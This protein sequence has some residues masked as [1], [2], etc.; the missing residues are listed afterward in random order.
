MVE[1]PADIRAPDTPR[2]S[3]A[4]RSP[5]PTSSADSRILIRGVRELQYRP[6]APVRD[7]EAEEMLHELRVEREGVVRG[8]DVESTLPD[9]RLTEGEHLRGVRVVAEAV[10]GHGPRLEPDLG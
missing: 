10:P 8:R 7:A 2:A 6:A 4:W 9:D 5:R 3:E 1:Y